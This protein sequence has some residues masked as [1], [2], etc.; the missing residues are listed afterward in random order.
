M[1]QAGVAIQHCGAPVFGMGV[2]DV[3]LPTMSFC[4]L[5]V[6][7]SRVHTQSVVV[8]PRLLSLSNSLWGAILLKAE[9][10]LTTSIHICVR[11]L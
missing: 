2:D 6:R 11:M 8:N 5:L 3:W 1:K 9:L 7:K 4:V 10:K